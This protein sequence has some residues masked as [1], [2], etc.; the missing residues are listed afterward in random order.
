MLKRLCFFY[1][2]RNTFQRLLKNKQVR[3]VLES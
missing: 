3:L 2:A 1:Y